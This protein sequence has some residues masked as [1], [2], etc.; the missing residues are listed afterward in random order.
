MAFLLFEHNIVDEYKE[1]S[2]EDKKALEVLNFVG[3]NYR[4]GLSVQL[5]RSQAPKKEDV[6]CVT[7]PEE[8]KESTVVLDVVKINNQANMASQF[9]RQTASSEYKKVSEDLKSATAKKKI[10][11]KKTMKD[12]MKQSVF[13]GQNWLGTNFIA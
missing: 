6:E 7:A 8:F 10:G 12:L 9:I 2:A 11:R 4:A 5:V 13:H 3:A 1:I